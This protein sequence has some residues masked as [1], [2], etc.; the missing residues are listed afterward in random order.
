MLGGIL[1]NPLVS[2]GMTAMTRG[3]VL[4]LRS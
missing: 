2:I 1:N 4:S 3:Q